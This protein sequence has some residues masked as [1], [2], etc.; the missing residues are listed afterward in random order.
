MWKW[1][2]SQRESPQE[3]GVT[4]RE[5]AKPVAATEETPAWKGTGCGHCDGTGIMRQD[6]NW[7][8]ACPFCGYG[9]L[10]DQSE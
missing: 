10:E 6:I 2:F 3:A 1:L 4:E 5:L 8:E 7:G 9:Q